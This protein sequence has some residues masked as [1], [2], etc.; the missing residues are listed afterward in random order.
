MNISNAY[1]LGIDS[2]MVRVEFSDSTNIT[3][4]DS[5]SPPDWYSSWIE[6]GNT[7]QPAKQ[8]PTD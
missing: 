6:E 8:P 2:S 1:C 3:I 4:I 7:P 5:S